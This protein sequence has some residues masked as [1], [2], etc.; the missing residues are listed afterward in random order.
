MHINKLENEMKWILLRKFVITKSD[1]Q[2]KEK[3]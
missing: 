2:E 1:S 3:I